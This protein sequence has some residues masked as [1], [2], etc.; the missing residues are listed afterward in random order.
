MFYN[1]GDYMEKLKELFE[2]NLTNE[3]LDDETKKLNKHGFEFLN[4]EKEY[5]DL[6]NRD[7][8]NAEKGKLL[9]RKMNALK[10]E[11]SNKID[12]KI[13]K[14]DFLSR[15]TLTFKDK[16]YILGI[17]ILALGNKIPI[18]FLDEL[19]RKKS[20]LGWLDN[21]TTIKEI[22]VKEYQS[23]D[24]WEE[25]Y[26]KSGIDGIARYTALNNK[27]IENFGDTLLDFYFY[28]DL[29]KEVILNL[30][31]NETVLFDLKS[32]DQINVID[33]AV[34]FETGDEILKYDS[35]KKVIEL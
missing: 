7:D 17:E 22:F 11:L 35:P 21:E 9:G 24:L 14:H 8:F 29:S 31:S 13:Q 27:F 2:K 30:T 18:N 25:I 6:I 4:S 16:L 33:Y 20:S 3:K 34:R 12:L 5:F 26:S 15:K 19:L 10:E 1:Q 32:K 23:F 28:N